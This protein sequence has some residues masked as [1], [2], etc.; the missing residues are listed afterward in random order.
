MYILVHIYISHIYVSY[1]MLTNIFAHLIR[2]FCS[3]MGSYQLVITDL[4]IK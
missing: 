2:I 1:A 4:I 3:I